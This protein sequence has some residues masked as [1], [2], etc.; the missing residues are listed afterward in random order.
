MST[1]NSEKNNEN[2][3]TTNVVNGKNKK[4]IY[5]ILFGL[6]LV[7]F[8]LGLMNYQS[9]KII[10]IEKTNKEIQKEN[11]LKEI[12]AQKQKLDEQSKILTKKG[13][14]EKDRFD[15]SRKQ[16]D[17]DTYK[18]ILS[19]IS[20]SYKALE[21]AKED[22]EKAKGY[23]IFRSAKKKEEQINDAEYEIEIWQRK[24]ELLKLEKRE[25]EIRLN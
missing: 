12:E 22:L 3:T 14:A 10:D 9:K 23:R 6:V 13:Q 18:E 4:L 5:I 20:N 7:I 11:Y 16:A 15:K 24:I 8:T 19:A 17:E 1:T 21:D 2:S 25:V